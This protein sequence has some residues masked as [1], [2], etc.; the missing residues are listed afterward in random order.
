[1]FERTT[2]FE[3]ATLLDRIG[4]AQRDPATK[5]A[6]TE[7]L[8][9]AFQGTEQAAGHAFAS[10]MV[11]LGLSSYPGLYALGPP[12]PG[13]AFGADWPGLLDQ[14]ALAH[15]VHHHDGAT[16]VIA[17]DRARPAQHEST[18]HPPTSAGLTCTDELVEV[19]LGEIV[20]AR[21][22]KVPRGLV[23]EA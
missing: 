21:T 2:G 19:S 17:P 1:M 9:I 15:T 8:R 10:R 14:A 12:Q 11:E 18:P 20:H 22:M 5:N 16:E 13:S 7:L 4:R 23:V 6:G 3:P